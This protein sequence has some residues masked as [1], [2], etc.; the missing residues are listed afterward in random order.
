MEYKAT[1]E[2]SMMILIIQR[3]KRDL[4]TRTRHSMEM[5]SLSKRESIKVKILK[6]MEINFLRPLTIMPN[7]VL[8]L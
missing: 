1:S 3:V 5:S 2:A 7:M 4:I 6:E 8:E